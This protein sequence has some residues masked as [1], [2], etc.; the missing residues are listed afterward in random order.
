MNDSYTQLN[1]WL[2]PGECARIV[3]FASHPDLPAWEPGRQ[4][5]GYEKL[6]IRQEVWMHWAVKR[7]REQLHNPAKYD[8]WLLRYPVGAYLFPHTDPSAEGFEHVRLNAVVTDSVGGTVIVGDS[9]LTLTAG[10]AYV[11]RPDLLPHS[12]TPVLTG[13]RLVLSVG[14]NIPVKADP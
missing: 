3:E 7:A 2:S 10:D 13:S 11:F 14:A 5:T 1:Q 4:G 12:V 8:A 9:A 6:D